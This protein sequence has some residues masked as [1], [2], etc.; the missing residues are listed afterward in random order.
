MMAILSSREVECGEDLPE[1]GRHGGY[2]CVVS[3]ERGEG[4]LVR[5]TGR[6]DARRADEGVW[7]SRINGDG[8]SWELS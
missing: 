1:I 4:R 8:D 3:F 6:R 2:V 7:R 5:C